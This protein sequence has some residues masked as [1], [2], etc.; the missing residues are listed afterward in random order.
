MEVYRIDPTKDV[1][2]D[3]FLQKH[4]SASIFHSAAWLEALRR[5][6]AY[7]PVV[8]TTS[9]PDGSVTNGLS[10]CEISNW[11]RGRRLVSLPFSDHCAPLVENSGQ[12]TSVVSHLQQ[13]LDRENWDS[14]E[15]RGIGLEDL[16]KSTRFEP[17]EIFF[18]HKLDLRPSLTDLF[19]SF[20]KDCVQRKI[21][22]AERAGIEYE[23]GR[24]DLLLAKFYDLLLLTR[25]RH[26]LPPQPV[27]WFRNLIACLADKVTI[28]VASKDGRP[29]ASILTLC[30]KHALVYKYGCSDLKFN[31]LGG[32][33]LLF[34]NAIQA[35]KKDQLSEFDLGRSDRD[36]PG[37]VAFK[38]RWGAARSTLT[39]W[40]FPSQGF[41]MVSTAARTPLVKNLLS[42]FPDPLLVAAGRMFY[43]Y[44]G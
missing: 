25:R 27:A 38:D 13:N 29:I 1:R 2:W 19:Q 9:P 35:A 15:I 44:I 32:T 39:Y 16:P 12:L 41:Q 4:P 7:N 37:L 30:H 43:K 6:Y 23:S 42:C 34:W 26:G 22:R 36:N 8:F 10:F 24:S 11:L 28:H 40:R 18:F 20:H 3:K 17:S 31:Y 21:K 33:Q 5:T 14:V